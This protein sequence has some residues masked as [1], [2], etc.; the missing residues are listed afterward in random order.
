MIGQWPPTSLYLLTQR[1][2]R[3]LKIHFQPTFIKVS[4]F[5]TFGTKRMLYTLYFYMYF[6][7]FQSCYSRQRKS[8]LSQSPHLPLTFDL[9]NGTSIFAPHRK[10]KDIH[11][12]FFKQQLKLL[13]FRLQNSFHLNLYY[14]S[15]QSHHIFSTQYTK[16]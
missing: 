1:P 13:L 8:L 3:V 9:L 12:N 2:Q 4:R 10:Y 5:I 16:V 15:I 6:C 11:V 7:I 14:D